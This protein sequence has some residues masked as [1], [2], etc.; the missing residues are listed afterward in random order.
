MGSSEIADSPVSLALYSAWAVRRDREQAARLLRS[1][2]VPGHVALRS[3]YRHLLDPASRIPMDDADLSEDRWIEIVRLECVGDSAL[4]RDP[5]DAAVHFRALMELETSSSLRIVT[6][7]AL[8]GLGDAARQADDLEA[9]A[10]HLA[11][12]LEV[13]TADG[14]RFGRARALVS[15]GYLA[16]VFSS[17]GDAGEYFSAAAGLCGQIPDP[18]YRA[19]AELGSAEVA[20]RIGDHTQARDA[21]SRALKVFDALGSHMGAGNAAERLAGAFRALADADEAAKA[22]LDALAHY[23]AAE[24]VIGEVNVLDALGEVHL[25]AGDTAAARSC[26][27]AAIARAGENGYRRGVLNSQQGLARTER[28]DENWRMAADLHR[29]TLIGYQELGDLV[30]QMHSYD[31]LAYCAR[32]AG[33]AEAE[34]AVRIESVQALERLRSSRSN[35]RVQAEYR[36]RFLG[37]YRVTMRTAV[38]TRSVAG[39]LFVLECLAGRRLAGLLEALPAATA[40]GMGLTAH[41]VALADQRLTGNLPATADRRERALRLL[42]ATAVRHG[43]A[44]RARNELE[45]LA[46]GLFLPLD[47]EEATGL[48]DA[49][50]DGCHVLMLATDATTPGE[51]SFLWRGPTGATRVGSWALDASTLAVM[52]DV[53]G[54]PNYYP[55][56]GEL[57]P[58]SSLLPA[59]LRADLAAAASPPPLLLIPIGTLWNVPWPAI[60]V[61]GTRVLG[62]TVELS[63]CPSLTVQRTLSRRTTSR[64]STET[65][66]W[67][68][69]TLDHHRYRLVAALGRPARGVSSS[70]Q[71]RAALLHNAGGRAVIV[72][73]GRSVEGG[74][75]LELQP[76]SVVTA[77]ELL[78]ARPPARLALICCW[79]LAHRE[80]STGD[81]L[82]LGVMAMLAGAH[83]VLATVAE[84]ADSMEATIFIQRILSSEHTTLAA[85]TRDATS[86]VL[87]QPGFRSLPV[88]HWAPVTTLASVGG[89]A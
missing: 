21:A 5:R 12:A 88:A 31:G 40:A 4:I 2:E 59:E 6:A 54:R 13:A 62:E 26:F 60:T 73:H 17:A 53:V 84:L 25:A 51:I 24:A 42:G 63:V 83:E 70:G 65:V 57:S 23:R 19:N 81:P 44:G 72:G 14:Y 39:V 22:L 77:A 64:P 1:V 87:A 68:N 28:T 86:A 61:T 85:A 20:L 16:M 9:A 10:Q 7:N 32:A 75:Y 66:L 34:L 11:A 80:A 29:A 56:I 49:V 27:T 38:E 8:Q 45:D 36:H 74:V 79:G 67:R 30:G 58:L 50:P 46:A 82:T 69:P 3:R 33:G 15:L 18:L 52:N 78:S 43:L 41:V 76:G 89:P 55:T 48:L 37:M 35:H 71:A 47:P